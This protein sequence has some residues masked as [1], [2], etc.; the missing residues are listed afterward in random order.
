VAAA[1][2]ILTGCTEGESPSAPGFD[3][4]SADATQERTGQL[5]VT[6]GV[7]GT[8]AAVSEALLQ[9][10][11]SGKQTA[12][13]YSAD[14]VITDE[15]PGSAADVMVGSCV[16]A[17]GQ[18][19]DTQ[20][21]G[22]DAAEEPFAA[23]LIT[24]TPAQADGSCAGG[25]GGGFPG[26][27]LGGGPG[28]GFGDL[29]EGMPSGGPVLRDGWSGEPGE[30]S[31]ELP[32]G[33]PT[34]MPDGGFPS[35][36]GRRIPGGIAIR[37]MASGIV[38][39]IEGDLVTVEQTSNQ[40]LI[41]AGQTGNQAGDLS[42]ADGTPE[43]VSRSFTIDAVAITTV[44]PAD[45]EALLVGKCVTA[46]GETDSSGRVSAETL[47]VSEPG[48]YGCQTAGATR[49]RSPTGGATPDGAAPGRGQTG[50]PGR[51]GGNQGGIQGGES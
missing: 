49:F 5:E 34:D 20:G 32:E 29:P 40:M 26:G 19:A 4:P 36:D 10:Q 8:I 37:N 41:G 2:L 17:I 46:R 21:D 24:V 1:S 42:E 7:S 33:G 12:V 30:G 13:A 31:A 44:K 47:A 16:T 22:S 38:T 18:A 11:D 25:F 45:S 14:T 43:T 51:T 35:E 48:E 6:P 23:E 15:V 50:L 28:E 39:A 9:V 3:A 27:S